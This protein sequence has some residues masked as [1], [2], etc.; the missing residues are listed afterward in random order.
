M[1]RITAALFGSS[2]ALPTLYAQSD[3]PAYGGNLWQY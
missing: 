1:M 2:V 3:W